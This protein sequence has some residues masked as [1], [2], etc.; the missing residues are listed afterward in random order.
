MLRASISSLQEAIVRERTLRCEYVANVTKYADECR[1]LDRAKDDHIVS[2][3]L[4][5]ADEDRVIA[6]LRADIEGEYEAYETLRRRFYSLYTD[7][8]CGD[9]GGLARAVAGRL[10]RCCDNA[11]DN[12]SRHVDDGAAATTV[13]DI[14]ASLRAGVRALAADAASAELGGRDAERYAADVV[15]RRLADACAA[16]TGCG[17]NARMDSFAALCHAID[18]MDERNRALADCANELDGQTES[19]QANLSEVATEY[20]TLS[21]RKSAKKC[22]ADVLDDFCAVTEQ[23]TVQQTR[24]LEFTRILAVDDKQIAEELNKIEQLKAKIAR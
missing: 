14:V 12:V 22:K 19:L 8:R 6:K 4:M 21:A 20:M 7:Q 1:D 13:R 2:L 5:L 15:T 17:G 11:A 18:S 23:I 16:N 3:Q 9:G 24:N 10:E